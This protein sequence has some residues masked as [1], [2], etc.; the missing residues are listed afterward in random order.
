MSRK[1]HFMR[2]S[3]SGQQIPRRVTVITRHE[4]MSNSDIVKTVERPTLGF[5]TKM[6]GNSV[7]FRADCFEWLK[8]SSANSLHAIVTDPPYGVKEYDADQLQKRDEGRG[9]IWRIPPAFDGHQRA[10][11]PRFTALD[12]KERQRISDFFTEWAKLAY[13]ALRPGG[14]LFIATNSFMSQLV[15]A[16]LIEGQLEFRGEVV[17]LVQTLRGGDRPKNAEK[18][19]PDVCSMPRGS[20]EPWGLFRKPLPARMTVA[21]CLREFQTGGIRRLPDGNPF[22]DVIP[23]ERTPQ[24]ERRIADH[25]SLKPQSFL[26]HLVFVSL[27]LGQGTIVDP[28]MGSGS[29][30][31]AAEHLGLRCIGIERDLKFYAMAEIA[32]PAL[33]RLTPDAMEREEIVEGQLKL[34]EEVPLNGDKSNLLPS[35]RTRYV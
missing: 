6:V 29:T 2:K 3:L 16:A 25:P 8:Q 33:A 14:H 15:Y 20:F 35:S 13:S 18:E 32:I 17:R 1:V 19:F 34:L 21:E 23:S 30:V 26:R 28:F 24:R 12:K 27:P 4:S 7:I 10:P 22:K 5:E 31:A 9:G 11:L